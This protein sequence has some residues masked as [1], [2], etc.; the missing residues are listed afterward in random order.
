MKKSSKK[1]IFIFFL[2]VLVFAVS[3]AYYLYNKGPLD[4][5]RS[6]AV[7]VNANELYSLFISNSLK[8]NEKFTSKILLVHGEVTEISVNSKLQKIVLL[9]T[10]T[11]GAY[12]NCTLEETDAGLLSTGPISVKGICSGIGEGDADLGI[13]GDVY[14]TRCIVTT[15]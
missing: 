9:K 8:A 7:T 15:K 11:D 5:K 13:P 14:L 2:I 1:A 10:G 4:V 3:A 12:V 6:S